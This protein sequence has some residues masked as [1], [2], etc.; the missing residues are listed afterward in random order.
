MNN[1]VSLFLMVWGCLFGGV[2]LGLYVSGETSIS[3]QPFLMIFVVIGLIVFGVGLR[4]IL[5]S[6]RL[7]HIKR[8][9]TQTMGMYLDSASPVSM[10]GVPL[11]YIKF[12][13]VNEDGAAIEVKTPSIYTIRQAEFYEKLGRFEVKY[14]N[15][16]AVITQNVDYRLLD[17]ML[18]AE[19]EKETPLA[20]LK[21]GGRPIIKNGYYFCD[22][23]GNEQEKPGK[24]KSCGAKITSKNYREPR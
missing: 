11:Y 12:S 18:E 16:V 10:N 15:K 5:K 8:K 1:F 20:P 23:C 22:Y 7:K 21:Q 6:L 14:I 2:P 9:G 17:K 3:E 4:N 13:F 19:K 24:C